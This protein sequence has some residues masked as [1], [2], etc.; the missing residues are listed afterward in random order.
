[1]TAFQI[2]C[3]SIIS[4]RNNNHN[5]LTLLQSL[6]SHDIDIDQPIKRGWTALH[7]AADHACTDMV[8]FLLANGACVHNKNN[9]NDTPLSLCFPL[10]RWNSQDADRK[11]VANHL[12]C[13]GAYN[14]TLMPIAKLWD[15]DHLE[16][17][18]QHVSIYFS[19]WYYF[20]F[21]T[22]GGVDSDMV[23]YVVA[24]LNA[25]LSH[26]RTS[27]SKKTMPSHVAT[28]WSIIFDLIQHRLSK[29]LP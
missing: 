24:Y 19:N 1:M 5:G 21:S 13:H 18:H 11:I 23:D 27:I 4:S 28:V 3:E 8:C 7:C 12:L 20:Q 2:A 26:L 17:F 15:E 25:A 10:C 16:H 9:F 22:C 29:G 6:L 14:D